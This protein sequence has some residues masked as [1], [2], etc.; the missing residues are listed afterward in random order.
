MSQHTITLKNKADTTYNIL[1]GWDRPLQGFFLVVFVGDDDDE[2]EMIYSNLN[3]IH[4]VNT[5]QP[6]H[7]QYFDELLDEMGVALPSDLKI[8]LEE[9]KQ[10]NRGNQNT[11]W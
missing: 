6:P 10:V 5:P 7:Y 8:A 11:S 1:T 3:D 4:L 2:D 9:D